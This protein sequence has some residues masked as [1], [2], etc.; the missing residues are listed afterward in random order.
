M[1]EFLNSYLFNK[2]LSLKDTAFCLFTVKRQ[3]RTSFIIQIQNNVLSELGGLK[4]EK[5]NLHLHM[6]KLIHVSD[7]NYKQQQ[8]KPSS[9]LM[10]TDQ[11]FLLKI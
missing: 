2:F 10:L 7:R 6:N 8:N 9:Y 5:K 11:L 3:V 1:H 4:K